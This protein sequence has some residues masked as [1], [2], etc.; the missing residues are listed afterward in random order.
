MA[1]TLA[2][3]ALLFVVTRV[4]PSLRDYSLMKNGVRV[5]ADIID[6]AGN[7][8]QKIYEPELRYPFRL[9]FKLPDGRTHE[10]Y[11]PLKDQRKTL[12]PGMKIPLYVD[13]KN[14]N[15]WTDRTDISWTENTLVGIILLP[16]ILLLLAISIFNRRG[17]LKTWQTGPA[18]TATVVETR[19]SP[20]APLSRLLRMVLA[21]SNDQRILT[22]LIPS[23]EANLQPGEVV[24]VIA[25]STRPSWA[26]LAKLYE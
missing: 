24:W 18:L 7:T 17:V 8:L 15:R 9:R 12:G 21:D 20:S 6:V 14:P 5:E 2:L 1:A 3:I 13:P 4:W 10:V 23:R 25:P 19:Q 22:T 26:M 11:E 16:F